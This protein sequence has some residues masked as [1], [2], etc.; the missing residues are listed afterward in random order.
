V[1]VYIVQAGDYSDRHIRGIFSTREKAEQYRKYYGGVY[2]SEIDDVV[3]EEW[4]VDKNVVENFPSGLQ[5]YIVGM[6]IDGE[7]VGENDPDYRHA[8]VREY[9]IEEVLKIGKKRRFKNFAKAEIVQVAIGHKRE[10]V[11][12]PGFETVMLAKDAKH[13]IKIANERRIQM[14]ANNT[15]PTK[16]E[17]LKSYYYQEWKSF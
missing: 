8:S 2:S 1:K 7:T 17:T 9:S 12:S 4:D 16:D 10:Y 6:S 5:G 14:L 13:A 3:I 11:Y 15:F